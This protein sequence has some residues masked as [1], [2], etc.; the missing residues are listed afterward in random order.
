[1]KR[2]GIKCRTRLRIKS[3]FIC[4][5]SSGKAWGEENTRENARRKL[6][7]GEE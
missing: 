2:L 3:I 4:K 6:G 1:M 5:C 7:S